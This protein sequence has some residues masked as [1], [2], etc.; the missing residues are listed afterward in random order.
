MS[1]VS[2]AESYG[3]FTVTATGTGAFLSAVNPD[4]STIGCQVTGAFNGSMTVEGSPD[5]LTWHTI[6]G[7]SSAG[8]LTSAI[9]AA[10]QYFFPYAAYRQFRLNV[11]TLVS[12]TPAVKFTVSED[13]MLGSGG[14]GESNLTPGTGIGGT[15]TTGGTPQTIAVA[16]GSRQ[17]GYVYNSAAAGTAYANEVLYVSENGTATTNSPALQPGGIFSILTTNAISILAATTGHPFDAEIR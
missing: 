17:G 8:A 1:I 7:E 3:V 11:G 15:I 16:N 9:T 4:G 13:P 10:G 5:G 12:G 2:A 6:T 14:A